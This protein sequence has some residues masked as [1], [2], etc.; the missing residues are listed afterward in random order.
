M[1]RSLLILGQVDGEQQL[2]VAQPSPSPRSPYPL[3]SPPVIEALVDLLAGQEDVG[4]GQEH[5]QA[6]A[7]QRQGP[8]L[9]GPHLLRV[10]RN[11]HLDRRA[12]KASETCQGLLLA[13]QSDPVL[14]PD[15]LSFIHSFSFIHRSP[16]LLGCMTASSCEALTA[17]QPCYEGG[18]H[19]CQ[20]LSPRDKPVT[21]VIVSTFK[22]RKLICVEL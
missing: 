22:M 16:S 18:P 20:L 12:G 17:C 7:R 19:V 1:S 13:R 9:E 14:H 11:H 3:E 10:S 21:Q 6:A 8:A 15:F 5:F 2:R 4:A